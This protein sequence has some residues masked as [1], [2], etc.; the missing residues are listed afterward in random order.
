M[1]K[2]ILFI[3]LIVF[4]TAFSGCGFLAD[5]LGEV[6]LESS[7]ESMA[8]GA[9]R[10]VAGR[11]VITDATLLETRI[12]R[13]RFSPVSG[14][15]RVGII[16]EEGQQ[17]GEVLGEERVIKFKTSGRT[18]NVDEHFCYANEEVYV[19]TDPSTTYGRPIQTLNKN[20]IVY[21]MQSTN[22]GWYQVKLTDNQVGWVYGAYLLPLIPTLNN[23]PKQ[24]HFH[25]CQTCN[26]YKQI[27]S[28]FNCSQCGGNKKIGCLYCDGRGYQNCSNCYGNG[29]VQCSSCKGY[30]YLICGR[31]RG[32][33]WERGFLG[34]HP[35][36]VC[37]G[38]GKIKCITQYQRM[39]F[40]NY[41]QDYIVRYGCSGTGALQCS[42][43]NGYRY[44]TCKYCD[45]SATQ[46]CNKC[47]GYGQFYHFV[48][49]EKC[50][51]KGGYWL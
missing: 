51:G 4:S 20:R 33:C 17:I 31:C 19:R 10:N 48:T 38:W 32:T 1:K 21:K 43:C 40:R 18:I 42:K 27:K 30:G 45:G 29:T 14:Y 5:I 9:I 37:N 24:Q 2:Y 26:G 8:S 44:E 16:T 46:T 22:D 34:K 50:N 25:Y 6:F 7:E 36:R 35:C 3:S 23:I 11:A 13:L 47:E 39:Y 12:A 28:I 41:Y 49:C 15:G